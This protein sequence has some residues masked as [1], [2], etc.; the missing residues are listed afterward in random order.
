MSSALM[1][2][3]RIDQTVSSSICR[4]EHVACIQRR[5]RGACRY[6]KWQK[7]HYGEQMAHKNRHV[8]QMTWAPG[9]PQFIEDEVI[10]EGGWVVQS[11][12][13]CI[14]HYQPP[15]PHV[16]SSIT[17]DLWLDHAHFLLGDDTDHVINWLAHRVQRPNEKINHALVV[18]GGQG[19]GKDTCSNPL[20]GQ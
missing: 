6:R 19:F 10:R 11:G 3:S 14:N 12:Y 15:K 7:I 18:G 16:K 2:L 4:Q 1:I 13:T 9:R 17:P 20:F 5:C 8:E